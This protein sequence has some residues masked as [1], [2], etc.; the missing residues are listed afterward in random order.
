MKKLIVTL[1][2]IATFALLL[3]IQVSAEPTD[4]ITAPYEIPTTEQLDKAL[5]GEMRGDAALY[6]AAAEE[7]GINVY[8]LC[9]VDAWETGWGSDC[10]GKN[11]RGNVR[12]KNTKYSDFDSAE[13]Y[14]NYN[15]RHLKVNYLTPGGCYYVGGQEKPRAD[16][17]AQV[18]FYGGYD[19]ESVS[20]W[21]C[22]SP[23]WVK[24]IDN[25]WAE[26]EGR[27]TE[28]A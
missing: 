19:I 7:Q 22:N 15:A 13:Q 26:I 8:F 21:Y 10:A 6:I 17:S 12:G 11:N 4:L 28:D 20:R 3:A 5:D 2:T 9:A 18:E 23:V 27:A 25:L 1:L 24:G 16:E 14:I